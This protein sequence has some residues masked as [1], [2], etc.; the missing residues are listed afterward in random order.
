MKAGPSARAITDAVEPI[1]QIAQRRVDGLAHPSGKIKTAIENDVSNCEA[2]RNNVITA[3]NQPIQPF[4]ACLGDA[5][6][7]RSS[8][9]FTRQPISEHIEPFGEAEPVIDIFGD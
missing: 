8:F 6:E 2:T 1:M 4:K 3:G 5:F 7:A 9:R